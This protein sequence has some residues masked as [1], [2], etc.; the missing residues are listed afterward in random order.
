MSNISEYCGCLPC[1]L[2]GFLDVHTTIEHVTDRGRRLMDQ[3]MATLGLCT[4]HHFGYTRGRKSRA[5]T[6]LDQ[7]PALA[8]GRIPFEEFFGDE[9][10]VLIPVQNFLLAE[11]DLEPWPEHNINRKTARHTRKL[12]IELNAKQLP[13]TVRSPSR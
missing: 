12:W 7:G 6:T 13:S 2:M 1:L 10:D 8:L 9:V 4:W 3:H 11:F 5:N